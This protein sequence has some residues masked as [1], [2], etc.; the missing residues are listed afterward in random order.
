MTLDEVGAYLQ[1]QGIGTLGSTL[2]TG[3]M[4]PAVNASD[5]MMVAV[6][7]YG[8]RYQTGL[9]RAFGDGQ[10]TRELTRLQIEVRGLVEDYKGARQKA[11]DA[12]LAMSALM[13]ATL[14]G[15]SYFTSIMLQ[16]PFPLMQDGAK[17]WVFV[18]NCELY[19]QAT[20]T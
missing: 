6:H 17:R 15:V 11:Q 16:P 8:G 7:E 2:W 10:I 20:T 5:P 9:S 3:F 13:S 19:K 1:A 18:F 4:P 14:S 12:Y